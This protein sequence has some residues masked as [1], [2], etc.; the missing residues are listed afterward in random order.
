MPLLVGYDGNGLMGFGLVVRTQMEV[1]KCS[2]RGT[3]GG[4][5]GALATATRAL[6][7]RLFGDHGNSRS[8]LLL[9]RM[10]LT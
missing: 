6:L 1:Q 7:L 10:Q 8:T 9:E 5:L 3:P 2:R 4:R